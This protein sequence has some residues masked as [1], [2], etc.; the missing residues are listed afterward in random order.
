M[1]PT[2]KALGD[3]RTNAALIA[4]VA[5]LG[6]L[7][8]SVLDATYG[9]G[10]FWKKFKPTL[11]VTNDRF[12]T[13]THHFDFRSLPVNWHGLYDSVVFDPPYRLNGTPDQPYDKAYGI[14][15][16]MRWQDKHQMIR[17]GITQCAQCVKTGGYLLLKCQDQVCSGQVRFQ[18]D[19]FTRHAETLTTSR[20]RKVDAFYFASDARPQPSGRKQV[21]AHGR[22][23]MLLVFQKLAARAR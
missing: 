6:Y 16:P 4:D 22:P 3:W 12:T 20:L 7:D 18:T 19:E 11:L 13:A 10:N 5:R 21:H 1:T 17:E 14:D 23:S 2:I 15:Q 9:E 8:G